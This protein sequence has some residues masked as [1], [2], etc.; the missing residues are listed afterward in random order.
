MPQRHVSVLADELIAMLDPKPGEL[1]V[2][3]TC[4]AGGH[5][6][7]VAQRLGETGTLIGIDRDP[8]AVEEFNRFSADAPG[9]TRL[10]EKDFVGGLK[11]LEQEGVSPELIYF[12]LGMSS[13]QIDSPERGFAYSYEAPLDMRMDPSQKLSAYTIINTWEQDEITRILR[14]YGEERFAAR[15]AAEIVRRRAEQDFTTTFQLVDA[16][17]AAIPAPARFGSGHPAKRTFQALR[18]AVNDEISQVEEA[19]PLA[20]EI[21]APGGRLAA[22]S[23]HS[24]EDRAVK[25]YFVDLAQGCICPPGLPVCV[26][27]HKPEGE[28]FTRKAVK[29]TGAE[30]S[31]NSRAKS[32]R[33]RV[34]RKLAPGEEIE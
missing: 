24:L 10:I 14:Q 4:G 7:L 22:I 17:T 28:L 31:A 26:C 21:L 25:R 1:A 18:I 19:L 30:I 32:A 9:E 12:D 16:I 8:G 5:A 2:D 15:I 23:F 3:C 13:M 27:G 33:L 11:Q 6:R 20:W 29:P 34:I